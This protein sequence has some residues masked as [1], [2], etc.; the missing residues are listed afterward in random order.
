MVSQI[1]TKGNVVLKCASM[2]DYWSGYSVCV[3]SMCD[4]HYVKQNLV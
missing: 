4:S 2:F 1:F 3:N